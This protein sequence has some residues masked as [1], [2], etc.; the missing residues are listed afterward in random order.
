MAGRKVY[1]VNPVAEALKAGRAVERVVVA[2]GRGDST[3]KAILNEA[4]KLGVPVEKAPRRELHKIAGSDHHQGVVAFIRGEFPYIDVHDLIGAWRASKAPAFFLILD[5]VQD[6]QNLGSLV[7]TAHAAGVHGV[8]IPKDRSA[9]VTPTVAKASAGATEHT[10]IAREVNIAR[11]IEALKAEGV[12]VG[13]VEADCEVDLYSA[14][15]S[16]D[17]ALVVGSEGKG[18]RRLVRKKCDFCVSI[19]MAGKVN[20]LNAAQAGAVA[21]FEAMRQRS[22][23]R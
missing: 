21:I 8:I 1:G 9:E 18:V 6:P 16:G 23:K 17:I 13:A 3:L 12:W 20:S 2:E 14:D 7:R 15:L 19:P 4:G 22:F 11:T 5:S 10:L